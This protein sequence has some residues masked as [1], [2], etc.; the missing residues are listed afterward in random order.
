MRLSKI[1]WTL[2]LTVAIQWVPVVIESGCHGSQHTDS[3]TGATCLW[4]QAPSP[5][6]N[7]ALTPRPLE[8]LQS[9]LPAAGTLSAEARE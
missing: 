7:A 8:S 6:P 4:T 3:H 9:Q 2:W 5:K 1:G